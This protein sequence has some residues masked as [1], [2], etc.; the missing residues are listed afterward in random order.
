VKKLN[1]ARNIMYIA[2][3]GMMILL[4]VVVYLLRARLFSISF[5]E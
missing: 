3:F 5:E 2:I 1:D 4:A